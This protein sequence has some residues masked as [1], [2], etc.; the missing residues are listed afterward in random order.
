MPVSLT[1]SAAACAAATAASAAAAVAIATVK[2]CF[3]CSSLASI[4]VLFG[5]VIVGYCFCLILPK[6]HPHLFGFCDYT[7]ENVNQNEYFTIVRWLIVK[8]VKYK[9][10]HSWT[11]TLLS[12]DSEVNSLFTHPNQLFLFAMKIYDII[13][14]KFF[15]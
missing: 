3:L 13:Q 10:M 4:S 1:T 7:K 8:L 6:L 9:S 11:L 12:F 2:A 15:T 14:T 5:A